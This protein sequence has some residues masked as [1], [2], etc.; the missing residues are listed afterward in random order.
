MGLKHR[1]DRIEEKLDPN[2]KEML[3]IIMDFRALAAAGAGPLPPRP[4]PL[5]PGYIAPLVTAVFLGGT[6]EQRREAVKWLRRDPQYQKDPCAN[7]PRPALAGDQEA[8]TSAP[9]TSLDKQE[10]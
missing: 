9:A 6:E 1:L 8:G 7:R 10:G 5:P 4:H 3:T 2:R